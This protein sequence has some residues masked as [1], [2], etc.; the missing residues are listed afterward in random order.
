MWDLFPEEKMQQVFHPRDG[1]W[2]TVVLFG[3]GYGAKI[4]KGGKY[5]Q[6]QS[7]RLFDVWIGGWWLNFESVIGIAEGLGIK[8]APY[9]TRITDWL[10]TCGAELEDVAGHSLTADEDSEQRVWPEGVVARTEP[11]LFNRRG[12]RVMWKLKF[13]DFK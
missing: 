8:I 6:D 13:R 4:Q 11:L 3:E 2:P 7:F 12:K 10:P 5:R 1:E 9:I